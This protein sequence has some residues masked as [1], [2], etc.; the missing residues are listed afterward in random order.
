MTSL[1]F[2]S[3]TFSSSRLAAL[4]IPAAVVG[5]LSAPA[6]HASGSGLGFYPTADIYPSGNFHFDADSFGNGLRTDLSNS[7]GLEY[8]FGSERDGLFGRNEIGFD[9]LASGFGNNSA[10]KRVALNFKTQLYN[11]SDKNER[12]SIGFTGMGNRANFGSTNV[13][14]LSYKGFSFGRVH[15]GLWKNIENGNGGSNTS[16][17]HLGFD[18]SIGK[19]TIIGVDYRSGPTGVIAP[20]VIYNINDKAGVELALGI[21]NNSN[22]S[23]RT[24]TYLAFDYNFDFKKRNVSPVNP[25]NLD[26]TPGDANPGA[27]P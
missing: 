8:G 4:L 15:A 24:T 27:N 2:S 14:L 17:L 13:S 23:P 7:V 9:Y 16:G 10:S 26:T 3:K 22:V 20:C 5:A 11:N 21:A 18:R 12:V 25:P 19:S 6:A 1:Y